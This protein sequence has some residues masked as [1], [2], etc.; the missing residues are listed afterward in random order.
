MTQP[1]VMV[2]PNVPGDIIV[3]ENIFKVNNNY[4]TIVYKQ[5]PAR[6]KPRSVV[7]QPP[8]KP[9]DF[10]GRG[11]ELA[12]LEKR[13]ADNEAVLVYGPDGLGKTALLKQAANGAAARA[14]PHGVLLL[15]GIGANSQG[16][17]LDD[18]SQQLFDA[19]YESEPPLKV[20]TTTARSYLSNNRP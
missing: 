14:L 1:A 11:A 12:E 5:A 2:T 15:E 19:L 8:R 6:V 18:L 3:G 17:G 7:A 13:I 20:T 4:G 16:L 10:V 9:R